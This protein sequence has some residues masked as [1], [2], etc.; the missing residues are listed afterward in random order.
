MADKGQRHTHFFSNMRTVFLSLG[1]L[2]T[3]GDPIY[4]MLL[5]KKAN[6]LGKGF[7][8]VEVASLILAEDNKMKGSPSTHCG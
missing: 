8:D 1:K 5:F 7:M 4:F 3:F 6:H 2:W